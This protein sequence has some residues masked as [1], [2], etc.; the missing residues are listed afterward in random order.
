MKTGI[1]RSKYCNYSLFTLFDQSLQ[2]SFGQKIYKCR[3]YLELLIE[4]KIW[5]RYFAAT[6][7]ALV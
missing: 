1:G 7:V 3:G 2:F 4:D 5:L 6:T